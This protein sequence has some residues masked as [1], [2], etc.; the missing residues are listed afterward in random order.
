VLSG[1]ESWNDIADYGEDKQE[2][3]KTFLSLPS[4]GGAE[5]ALAVMRHMMSK[6]KLAVKETETGVCWLPEDKLMGAL[7]IQID[8]YRLSTA[9]RWSQSGL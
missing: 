3:L 6:L 4:G 8:P 2:W 9:R 7:A 1:A 5:P